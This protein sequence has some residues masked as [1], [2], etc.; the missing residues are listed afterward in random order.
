M[1][2]VLQAVWSLSF[3]LATLSFGVMAALI[4]A[5]L[6]RQRRDRQ[7]PARSVKL[8]LDLLAYSKGEIDAPHL[9]TNS[10]HDRD[11]ILKTALDVAR[12]LNGDAL[13]RLVGLMRTASLDVHY[14]RL[15]VRGHIP[16]RVA[17]IE[18]LRM[19][20]DEETARTLKHLQDS[21]SFRICV[22]AMRTSIEIGDPPDLAAVLKL[23]ERPEGAR[24]LALF[25]IVE[26]CVH[27]NLPVALAFLA[28]GLPRESQVMTLKAIGT[29]R[30]PMAFTAITRSTN[31]MDPEVRA[32]AITALRALGAPGTAPWFIAALRDVDWR[33]RLKAVEGLG[34][35]GGSEDRASIE[36]LLNDSVWWIRFRA[37]EALQRVQLVTPPPA[38]HEKKKQARK[39]TPR[40]A[41][42]KA[43][44]PP[45]GEDTQPRRTTSAR[46]DAG[47][48]GSRARAQPKRR[49]AS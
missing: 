39:I 31:D 29:S 30:S 27:A 35:C 18:N 22:A 16:D 11:L 25:K 7:L 19:F 23:V 34:Q 4:V 24:S 44:R 13:Q 20:R 10:R 15:A 1:S 26:T 32:G 33:V 37:G 46:K 5:R 21:T 3:V 28:A 2:S 40:A 14:R 45:P 12:A 8:I 42:A 49:A 38:H 17:A 43:G 47:P 36:P 9:K 6:V 48:G 41:A